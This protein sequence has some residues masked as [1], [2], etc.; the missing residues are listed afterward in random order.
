MSPLLALKENR[1]SL[2]TEWVDESHTE[3]T[4]LDIGGGY[5]MS[6]HQVL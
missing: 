2:G 3:G 1:R 4:R 5:K 6:G